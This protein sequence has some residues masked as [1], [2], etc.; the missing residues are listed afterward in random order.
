MGAH[1]V[2]L[3]V[4]EKTNILQASQRVPLEVLQKLLGHVA[5]DLALSLTLR[6]HLV[7]SLLEVASVDFVVAAQLTCLHALGLHKHSLSCL[8]IF[9]VVLGKN[10]ILMDLDHLN[11]GLFEGLANEDLEDRLDFEIIVEEVWVVIV[12]LDSLIGAFLV[13]DVSGGGWAVDVVVWFDV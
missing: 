5:S 6:Q 3:F 2:G 7:H 8:L 13:R 1:R 10:G 9:G 4:T 12:D 11:A